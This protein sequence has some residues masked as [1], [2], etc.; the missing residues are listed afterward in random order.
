MKVT[1]VPNQAR[2]NPLCEKGGTQIVYVI[3][4][5]SKIVL[6]YR[7]VNFS[8]FFNAIKNS[9]FLDKKGKKIVKVL[10]QD[11]KVHYEI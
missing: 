8:N 2:L 9:G 3:K 11:L 5:G 1:M 10:D 7:V 6:G 4:E